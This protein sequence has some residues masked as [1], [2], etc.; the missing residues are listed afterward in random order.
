ML[1]IILLILLI[2]LLFVI[3]CCLFSIDIKIS[4]YDF[5]FSTFFKKGLKRLDDRFG[6]WFITGKQGSNKSYMATYLLSRQSPKI[7]NKV[8]T[9]VKSLKNSN[10]DIV[11]FDTVQELYHNTEEYC[12]FIIDE[13]SRK[14]D[15][16]SRTDTQF[17]A[18]LNQSRKRKRIVIMI[19]QEWRELPMWL[20]RPAKYMFTSKPTR[21]L[22]L[23]GVYTCVVGDAENLVFDKD[24]GEYNC[25]TIKY[26]F[27]R[28]NKRIADMYD[29]FEAIN[30]L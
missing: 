18:W 12:I 28:R 25:P 30:I 6:V 1:N 5:R 21:I 27:Y 2:I 29:T 11:Y 26:I 19:T 7:C 14:Y 20:R 10:F 3:I 4:K 24:E 8:F 22:S 17:Y 9:N 15:K 23:F 13:V 16:N